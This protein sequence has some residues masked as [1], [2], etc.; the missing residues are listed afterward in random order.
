MTK[1][2]I[3]MSG[4]VDST[5]AAYLLKEKGFDLVGLTMRLYPPTPEKFIGENG[6]L[7][8]HRID[9]TQDEESAR[10]M[11]QSLG[12]DFHLVDLS[13][14]FEEKVIRPFIK[15]YEKGWTPNP[16]VFCNKYL[17]FGA[18]FSY[19]KIYGLD[20]VSTGHYASV[21]S[22]Q[23][24]YQLKRGRD[25]SKDQSYMLFQMGQEE[26]SK[27]LF[28]LG[29]FY[30]EEVRTIAEKAGLASWNRPD[31][32]DI[33][34]IPD[35]NY[36]EFCQNH[37]HK[38]YPPGTLVNRRGE[39]LGKG[40]SPMA[41]TIGQRRGLGL[42]LPRPAY[43]LDKNMERGEVI[44]GDE[45][46]L[47]FQEI[48]CPDWNWMSGK[49]PEGLCRA[50]VK[51]RYLAKEAP[52][53]IKSLSSSSGPDQVLIRFDRPQRAPAPGQSAVAYD[54]DLVLGGGTIT[55]IFDPEDGEK[56]F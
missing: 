15:T 21:E 41:Y 14:H 37:D 39:V 4:G 20:F 1:V 22:V 51:I 33:C 19:A 46:E 44:V 24:T 28:P 18:L 30:K 40:K 5:V 47:F 38:I 17:K 49:R 3:A 45:E 55:K 27:V 52:C 6:E 53:L 34:F 56:N 29:G 54:G 12:I 42:A 9:L 43:V 50:Q 36:V 35:G 7:D 16:C 8:I 48:F 31:S 25:Q 23:G 11:A 10:D 2:L 26:L 13:A 32:E